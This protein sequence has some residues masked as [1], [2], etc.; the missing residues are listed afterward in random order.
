[1]NFGDVVSM[2]SAV[3]QLG[4]GVKIRGSATMKPH[5]GRQLVF[6]FLGSQDMANPGAFSAR[7]QLKRLGWIPGPELQAQFDAEAQEATAPGAEA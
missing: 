6:L 5:T 2:K 3:V 1:M 4:D 7:A